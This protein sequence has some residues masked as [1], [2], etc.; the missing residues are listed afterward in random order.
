MKRNS[1]HKTINSNCPL[2]QHY[3]VFG[4]GGR[5]LHLLQIVKIKTFPFSNSSIF[6]LSM[7]FM[8]IIGHRHLSM[9]RR[10][11]WAF[12]TSFIEAVKSMQ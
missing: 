11:C 8:D 7:D 10:A 6:L 12:L 3:I 4:V 2:S 1:E 5:H 9:H